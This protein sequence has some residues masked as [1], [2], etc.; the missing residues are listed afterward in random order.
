[1]ALP[2]PISKATETDLL[3]QFADPLQQD[4]PDVSPDDL[5]K[6]VLNPFLKMTLGWNAELDLEAVVWSFRTSTP[7]QMHN[8][9]Y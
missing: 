1:M 2:M 4:N 6:E 5:W 3:S 7:P 9:T 8:V